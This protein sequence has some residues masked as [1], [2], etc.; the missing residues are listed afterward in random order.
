MPG[1]K[2][3]GCIFHMTQA[4]WGKTQEL[5]LQRAYNED[6]SVHK[7]VKT[8]MALPFLPAGHVVPAFDKLKE[9]PLLGPITE[10]LSY[11]ENTWIYNNTYP[12]K[13]WCMYRQPIRTNNDIEAWHRRLNKKGVKNKSHSMC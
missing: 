5:G 12:V 11:M 1:V 7:F 8:L 4:I 9:K 2:I 3:K 6:D 13:P 10:L